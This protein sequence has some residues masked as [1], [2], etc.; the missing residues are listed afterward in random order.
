MQP[1]QFRI[2]ARTLASKTRRPQLV[3]ESCHQND[4]LVGYTT[5]L[6]PTPFHCHPPSEGQ[7]NGEGTKDGENDAN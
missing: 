3:N 5:T 1:V 7:A 2:Q 4:I 6:V